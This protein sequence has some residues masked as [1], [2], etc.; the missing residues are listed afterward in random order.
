MHPSQLTLGS[1]E[2]MSVKGGI[3]TATSA[4]SKRWCIRRKVVRV[5][6]HRPRVGLTTTIKPGTTIR[7]A[8]VRSAINLQ[9]KAARHIAAHDHHAVITGGPGT[10][11]TWLYDELASKLRGSQDVIVC[12]PTATAAAHLPRCTFGGRTFDSVT[13]SRAIMPS[14]WKADTADRYHTQQRRSRKKAGGK[15]SDKRSRR[16]PRRLTVFVDEVSMVSAGQLDRLYEILLNRKLPFRIVLGGD[17]NQLPPPGGLN[18]WASEFVAELMRINAPVYTLSYNWRF[19]RCPK[20][21]AFNIALRARDFS[22]AFEL[23]V[24]AAMQHPK[25]SDEHHRSRY[26]AYTHR[27]LAAVNK[28]EHDRLV[29]AGANTKTYVGGD[30]SRITLCDGELV[31]IRENVYDRAAKQYSQ[32]N[33]Q[34]GVAI[35]RSSDIVSVEE[36]T[37]LPIRLENGDLLLVSPKDLLNSNGAASCN[38]RGLKRRA[39]WTF[40][41]MVEPCTG[42]T[43]HAAQGAT[44]ADGDTLTVDMHN[45]PN[46]ELCLVALTR[47]PLFK[48][49]RVINVDVDAFKRLFS[50]CP[51]GHDQSK[52]TANRPSAACSQARIDQRQAWIDYTETHVVHVPFTPTHNCTEPRHEHPCQSNRA[53]RLPKPAAARARA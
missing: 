35:I 20:M 21:Q 44:M 36:S 30:G 51:C 10:G 24:A 29:K 28:A 26:V 53:E 47:H 41:G 49:L 18:P 2:T 11:K 13:V 46:Y 48:Q 6:K 25:V 7:V 14:F 17:H 42:F 40:V 33:G 37:K 22:A 15:L 3:V 34:T 38:K 45:M 8:V 9:D 43:A 23:L 39:L 1:D 27:Q 32:R 31:A 19:E 4:K 12:A 50:L 5:G 16:Q 52:P